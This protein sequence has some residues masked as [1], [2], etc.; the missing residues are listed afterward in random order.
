MARQKQNKVSQVGL[1]VCDI[2]DALPKAKMVYSSAT[3][4][5]Y[6]RNLAYCKRLGLWGRGTAF[7]DVKSFITEIEAAGLPALELIARDMKQSGLF[8]SR[9]LSFDGVDYGRIT[10]ILTE[11]QRDIYNLLCTAWQYALQNIDAAL[12]ITAT[13]ANGKVDGKAKRAAYSAF[14]GRHLM[15]FQSVLLGMQMPSVIDDIEKQLHAGHCCIIQLVNTN[16]ASMERNLAELDDESDL[17][18]LDM[19]PRTMLLQ[20]IQTSFPV[21]QTEN[22]TD[23]DGK[24]RIRPVKDSSGNVVLN[25]QAVAMRE[26]LLIKMGSIKCPEG[27]LEILLNHFGC[28]N[29]AEVT[30]RSRRVVRQQIDGVEKVVIEQRSTVKCVKEAQDFQDGKRLILVFSDAGGTGTSYH[31]SLDALNQRRR[32]H[33]LVQGGWIADGALQGLGRS[34][35]SSQRCAP[36]YQLVCTNLE[37][38]KRFLSSIARRLEMLGAVTKGQRNATGGGVFKEEDNLEGPI[39][40]EAL[41]EL[42]KDI[43]DG[44]IPEI[45]LEDFEKQTGLKISTDE[46]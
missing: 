4:A 13:N 42:F 35:R 37:G 22:Y 23:G 26:D 12:Q 6:A 16:E 14:Y 27:P 39:A 32:Y 43:I 31:S 41:L 33:Y 40:R 15:F 3:G 19:T 10:H 8:V 9:G 25:R 24:A 28:D 1:A 17:D 46:E 34:H 36:F 18:D 29:V 30:G 2:Q 5:T 11:D 7:P 45:T 44:K 20:M 38:Q 21:T